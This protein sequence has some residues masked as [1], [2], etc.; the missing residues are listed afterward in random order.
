M[1]LAAQ[2]S[3]F[4]NV[5][6]D[7]DGMDLRAIISGSAITRPL[8]KILS[9]R[10]LVEIDNLLLPVPGF[11]SGAKRFTHNLDVGHAAAWFI[12]KA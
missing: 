10:I 11:Y 12:E 3:V 6:S 7:S 9:C 1:D 8:D 2:A 4:G 5:A